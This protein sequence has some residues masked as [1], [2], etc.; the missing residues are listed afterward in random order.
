MHL[1]LDLPTPLY[2]SWVIYL[3]IVRKDGPEG[4]GRKT[5]KIETLLSGSDGTESKLEPSYFEHFYISYRLLLV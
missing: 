2:I 4:S 5:F 3:L 1:I